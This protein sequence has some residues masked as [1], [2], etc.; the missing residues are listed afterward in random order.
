MAVQF[1]PELTPAELAG[2]IDREADWLREHGVDGEALLAEAR[3]R[4]QELRGRAHTLF[5]AFWTRIAQSPEN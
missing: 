1:H 4:E 2:W 3:H 5:D